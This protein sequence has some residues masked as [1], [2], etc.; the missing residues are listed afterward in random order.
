MESAGG[1]PAPRRAADVRGKQRA[2]QRDIGRLSRFVDNLSGLSVLRL[3]RNNFTGPLPTLYGLLLQVLS[4][5]HNRLTGLVPPPLLHMPADMEMVSLAGNLL[6]PV[7]QFVTTVQN[8]VA[9]AAATGSFCRLGPGP[10][11]PDVTSLLAIAAALH[12]PEVLARSWKRN[13]ACLGWLGVHCEGED[14]DNG[15]RRRVKGINLSRLGLNGTMDPA[16]ASLVSLRFISLSGNNISGGV[17]PAIATQLPSL[18]VLDVSDNALAGKLPKFS[19]DVEVC[20]EGN[21]GLNISSFSPPGISGNQRSSLVV[22]AAAVLE[23][24]CFF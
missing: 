23:L 11:D 7:P 6:G 21:P 17:P 20:A 1:P 12:F 22:A 19:R 16:F 9:E 8:D 3:D 10:C 18:R 4:V 13:D 15:G 2:C 5:A 24:L 14:M